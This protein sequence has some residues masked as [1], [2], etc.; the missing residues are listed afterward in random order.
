MPVLAPRFA[1]PTSLH[2]VD[3]LL[4]TGS[5]S[6]SSPLLRNSRLVRS[7]PWGGGLIDGR[8]REPLSPTRGSALQR[9]KSVPSLSPTLSLGPVYPFTVRPWKC[10][11]VSRWGMMCSV[12]RRGMAIGPK[13]LAGRN[14]SLE[15]VERSRSPGPAPPLYRGALVVGPVAGDGIERVRHCEESSQPAGISAPVN[16]P[17]G[18]PPRSQR[19]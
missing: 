4:V 2:Y 19:S 14:W 5:V 8:A 7:R 18:Y 15:A 17:S 11:T 10:S 1:H 3:Q 9:A 13:P 12:R 6:I 16:G